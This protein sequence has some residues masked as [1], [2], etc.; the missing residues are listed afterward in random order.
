MW[1]RN[2]W[3]AARDPY[4]PVPRRIWKALI[5]AAVGLVGVYFVWPR[6]RLEWLVMD[7][8]ANPASPTAREAAWRLGEIGR[9]AEGALRPL[10]TVLDLGPIEQPAS[11]DPAGPTSVHQIGP[12]SVEAA[13][14]IR[15][16]GSPETAEE[17]LRRLKECRNSVDG[18]GVGAARLYIA[19]QNA[20]DLRAGPEAGDAAVVSEVFDVLRD[21]QNAPICSVL[22]NWLHARSLV[23]PDMDRDE[24]IKTVL[25]DCVSRLRIEAA[26]R[27]LVAWA[28]QDP[29]VVPV[30]LEEERRAY[31]EHPQDF[32]SSGVLYQPIRGRENATIRRSLPLMTREL[33]GP[34]A[35]LIVRLLAET[36]W[37]ESRQDE[38]YRRE[39]PRAE[40]LAEYLRQ[41]LWDDEPRVRQGVAQTLTRI[42]ETAEGGVDAVHFLTDGPIPIRLE[43]LLTDQDQPV[44]LASAVALWKIRQLSEPGLEELLAGL[45]SGDAA[46]RAIA[47]EFFLELG[48]RDA[49]AV[50]ALVGRLDDG[51]SAAR[52]AILQSLAAIGPSARKSIP[53]IVA[54]LKSEDARTV[55]AAIGSLAEFGPDARE[56]IAPLWEVF[57]NSEDVEIRRQANLA[58]SKI[59]P[60]RRNGK[61]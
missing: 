6:V 53:A 60:G 24:R 36:Y 20:G 2:W 39:P 37:F 54:S 58:M 7:L 13:E 34:D 56:A 15:K 29:S 61:P 5:L 47:G 55:Q 46:A 43:A 59:D 23:S 51:G 38:H 4:D 28:E 3:E 33:R 45:D 17:L 32:T 8:Y 48:P 35:P 18:A 21:S 1:W 25:I 40:V 19:L 42:A 12:L 11:A 57:L 49:W 14:A 50:A 16:I 52:V 41:T 26:G 10:I 31:R 27:I 9:T 22:L 30:I 44:R